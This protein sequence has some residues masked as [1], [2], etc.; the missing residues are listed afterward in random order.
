MKI[1][2]KLIS[3]GEEC[4]NCIEEKRKNELNKEELE[5]ITETIKHALDTF[6]FPAF[7]GGMYETLDGIREKLEKQLTYE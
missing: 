5:A 6:T 2:G 7:T 1:D 4:P 3:V